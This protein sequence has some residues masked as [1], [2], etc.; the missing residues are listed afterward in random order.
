MNKVLNSSSFSILA[1]NNR[2]IYS[3][4]LEHHAEWKEEII[5]IDAKMFLLYTDVITRE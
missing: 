2:D 5:L 4:K 1:L 3:M